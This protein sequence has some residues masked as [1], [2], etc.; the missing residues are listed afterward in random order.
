M[1][2]QTV[3]FE[4][5]PAG[6]SPTRYVDH[7]LT[8]LEI[9]LLI[10]RELFA[11]GDAVQIGTH[12]RCQRYPNILRTNTFIY[13]E[14]VHT[15]YTETLLVM[16]LHSDFQ[17]GIIFRH[18][19]FDDIEPHRDGW[20]AELHPV[21]YQTEELSGPIEPHVFAR[22]RHVF[23]CFQTSIKARYLRSWLYQDL[24]P[25][26]NEIADEEPFACL[27]QL[28]GRSVDLRYGHL[29]ACLV[30]DDSRS[31]DLNVDALKDWIN[32]HAERVIQETRIFRGCEGIGVSFQAVLR[33]PEDRCL[34]IPAQYPLSR[35]RF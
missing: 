33:Q 7:A 5:L 34:C 19:P 18:D 8:S 13:Q 29:Q 9:R 25:E 6:R 16:H 22:F 2:Q 30:L 26:L 21:R 15:L 27:G 32:Q 10:Y 4:R 11:V 17:P 3:H 31:G 24:T 28:L 12:K 23:I 20:P 35:W 14:A 1:S